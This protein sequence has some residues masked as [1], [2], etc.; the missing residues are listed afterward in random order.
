MN[1]R[2]NYLDA[3]ASSSSAAAA[4]TSLAATAVNDE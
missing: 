4:A 1:E 2:P 3:S